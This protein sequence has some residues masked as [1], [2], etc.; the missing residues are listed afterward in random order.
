M[1]SDPIPAINLNPKVWYRIAEQAVDT[2][3]NND[4][5]G[6]DSN[7]ANLHVWPV[8]RDKKTVEAYWQFVSRI[9]L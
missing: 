8:K 9:N 3:S 6:D 2:N 7:D 1:L 5:K 4:S